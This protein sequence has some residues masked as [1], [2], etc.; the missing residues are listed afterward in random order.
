MSEGKK[1]VGV[2][3]LV[4]TKVR[5]LIY[6]EYAP[7]EVLSERKLTD[8]LSKIKEVSCSRVSLRKGDRPTR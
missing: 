6:E 1:S 4:Y 7:A 8:D 3:E 2:A 5:E